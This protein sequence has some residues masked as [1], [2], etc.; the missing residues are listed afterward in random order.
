MKLNQMAFTSESSQANRK[1]GQPGHARKCLCASRAG[2]SERSL[3]RLCVRGCMVA[4]NDSS[5][6][7]FNEASPQGL[8]LAPAAWYYVGSV[9]EISAA[10]RRFNLPGEQGYVAFCTS[11]QEVAVL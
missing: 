8:T 7:S 6:P 3:L 10:P 11:A 5:D 4:L 2:S 9:S 1:N